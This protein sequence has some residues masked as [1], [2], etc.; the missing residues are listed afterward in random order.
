MTL[1]P[2][3]VAELWRLQAD[4]KRGFFTT[5]TDTIST[6]ALEELADAAI[7]AADENAQLVA[8]IKS[9]HNG[10]GETGRHLGWP[11]P[12]SPLA[13]LNELLVEQASLA[14][15]ELRDENARLRA[16]LHHDCAGCPGCSSNDCPDALD[17][18][19]AERDEL[20]GQ[21]D[22]IA[23][24]VQPFDV[25][26]S[27]VQELPPLPDAVR[28]LV[29]ERDELLAEVAVYLEAFRRTDWDRMVSDE[30]RNPELAGARQRLVARIRA[31]ENNHDQ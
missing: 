11:E 13:A 18:L 6:S 5:N 23:S 19:R 12:E 2:D 21:L 22:D 17:A 26:D 1:P 15:S 16:R 10:Y 8:R 24:Y 31:K 4:V 9:A 30:M 14:D 25:E 27:A 7:A 29:A 3:R 28:G 20:R